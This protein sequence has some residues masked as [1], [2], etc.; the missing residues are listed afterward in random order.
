MCEIEENLTKRNNSKQVDK[1]NLLII[2]LQID[3]R[4]K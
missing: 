2:V 3:K 4:D 1:R